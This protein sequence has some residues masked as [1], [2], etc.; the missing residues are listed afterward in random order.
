MTRLASVSRW[1][2]RPQPIRI[3]TLV[4]SHAFVQRRP[5]GDPTL[6]PK[7]QLFPIAGALMVLSLTVACGDNLK[8]GSPESAVDAASSTDA[9]STD[10]SWTDAISGAVPMVLSNTPLSL[11]TNVSINKKP[12]ATFS[13]AMNATTIN[14]LTFT[15]KQ[16]SVSVPGTVTL[17]GA[18]NTATF[19]PAGPLE[20]DLLYTATL[21]TGAKGTSNTALAADHVWTFTTAGCSSQATIDLRSASA[22]AVLAGSAITNTGLTAITGDLGVSPGTAVTGFGPGVVVGTQHPGDATAAQAIADLAIAYDDAAGRTQCRVSVAG[23][24][25][26]QTLTPALYHSASSLEVSSGNLTLDAQGDADAV[27][28]FQMATTLSATVGRQ[29]ILING[30]RSANIFWQVGTSATLASTSVFVGTLMADQSITMGTGATLNG[31]ALAHVAAATL[32]TNTIVKP[33]L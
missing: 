15:V 17:D 24:L 28:V 33:A 30:A 7:S 12:T 2:V 29:V 9:S 20:I 21:T 4:G 19:T 8:P 26:G 32:D 16:G 3:H 6:K 13:E 5:H 11:A 22:F 18:T 31:R 27:F 25:G 10:A 1:I 23:N 14:D